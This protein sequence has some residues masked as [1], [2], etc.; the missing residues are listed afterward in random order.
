MAR[1]RTKQRA[2]AGLLGKDLT[3]R[4]RGVCELCGAKDEPRPYELAP[5][6]VEPD[7]ERALLACARCR[8]WLDGAEIE[9][10]QARFLSTAVWSDV[11]PVKLAAARLLLAVDDPH[12]PWVRDALEVIDVDPDTGEFRVHEDEDVA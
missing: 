12:N 5:F 4:C 1:K 11:A 10:L 2:A 9:P 3:R 6:P 7:L 8:S